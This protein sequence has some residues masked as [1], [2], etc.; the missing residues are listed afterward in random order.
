MGLRAGREKQ[1]EATGEDQI[2]A[3]LETETWLEPLSV[4]G[5]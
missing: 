2:R 1:S 4:Y 5:I 3:P